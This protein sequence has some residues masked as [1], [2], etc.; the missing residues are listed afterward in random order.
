MK[1]TLSKLKNEASKGIYS[2]HM[3]QL[4]G[5]YTMR[6]ALSIQEKYK[7]IIRRI[8]DASNAEDVVQIASD[9]TAA[10]RSY[11]TY[12]LKDALQHFFKDIDLNA[13]MN[14]QQREK[15]LALLL[16][17]HFHPVRCSTYKYT[18]PNTENLMTMESAEDPL[19]LLCVHGITLHLYNHE[20]RRLVTMV[21]YVDNIDVESSMHS[22]V[23]WKMD[24]FNK[25]KNKTQLYTTLI[26]AMSLRDIIMHKNNE[27][28]L[29][30]ANELKSFKQKKLIQLVIMF[31]KRGLRE[32]Y[33]M[34][35]TLLLDHGNIESNYIA[36]TLYDIL[37]SDAHTDTNEQMQ[38]FTCLPY[39][40]KQLF[41]GAMQSTMKYTTRI[42]DIENEVIPYEQQICMMRCSDYVKQKAMSK[43]KEIKNRSDDSGYKAKQ[44]LDGLLRIPFGHYY[45]E[46]IVQ[47]RD[48]NI[49][50]FKTLYDS[51]CKLADND[52]SWAINVV[53]NVDVVINID[54]LNHRHANEMENYIVNYV[55]KRLCGADRGSIIDMICIFNNMIRAASKP[56]GPKIRHSGRKRGDI[57][58]DLIITLK[59]CYKNNTHLLDDI[60]TFMGFHTYIGINPREA[61]CILDNIRKNNDYIVNYMSNVSKTLDTAVYGHLDAKRSMQRII[62]QW[63][64]G[65]QTGRCLGFEG[66]PG[67]GK[68]SFA[69][70]GV[71]QCLR[72]EDGASRPFAFIA[73]GGSSNASYLEGHSYTYVGSTW[74]KVADILMEK[75]C[76]NPIIFIDE[77]DK[78]S[79]TEHGKE[80]NGILTHLIDSTQNSEFYDKYFTGVPLDMS[81]A[82]FIF[83]YNDASVLDKIVL[84]R[85]HR[86]QFD[87]LTI[88]DKIVVA[89]EHIIP[90]LLQTVGLVGHIVIPD[91]TVIH[92]IRK[93]TRESGVR[94]LKE[95]L[96]DIV[97]ETNLTFMKNFEASFFPKTITIHDVDTVYMKTKI[98]Y[99]DVCPASTPLVGVVY[100]MWANVYKEGGI[101]PIEV[102]L[103]PSDTLFEFKLTGM[104]GD[105]MKESMNV[106][107]TVVWSV[108]FTEEE[109]QKIYSYCKETKMQGIHVHCPEGATPKDGPSAGLAIAIAMYS[110]LHSIFEECLVSN[111]VA[112]TGEINLRGEICAIGGLDCK[113]RGGFNVGIEKYYY[114]SENA[115]DFEL[116]K[117]SSPSL[118]QRGVFYAVDHIRDVLPGIIIRQN[119]CI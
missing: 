71:A 70:N 80:I 101:L 102:S 10:M 109:R 91:E 104:Q 111:M 43:L 67:C 33:H 97:S 99:M 47:C 58:N 72:N 56:R 98:P 44:Y 103:F 65:E 116:F 107:K 12:H 89:R 4:N 35:Y 64:N 34:L 29:F 77:L 79:R 54:D 52:N 2:S 119:I 59:W 90:Q 84:D 37:T 22:Y 115:K 95:L 75:Q 24:Q 83:S 112:M 118:F 81:R 18:G 3:N 49:E 38:I 48:K 26:G 105:V 66:P 53:T 86:I 69:K 1:Q 57:I 25:K 7:S 28:A 13:Y 23:R 42:M 85:I 108:L 21:G 17:K 16:L 110:R 45:V 76:M 40:M 8:N 96:Y 19:L 50:L 61:S 9:V 36:Y 63:I 82:L 11:G 87:A 93:Y 41:R 15:K 51:Y 117:A 74:G 92:I 78:V 30:Y 32:K 46:N 100:G 20:R 5:V 39:A 106:A 14:A 88:D 6:T 62:A 68:T 27:D 31:N 73:L 114:P 113:F 94:R 55:K 60:L